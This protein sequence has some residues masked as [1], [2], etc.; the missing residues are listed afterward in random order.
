V[1]GLRIR[2]PQPA[3]VLALI[4][5]VVAMAGTAYAAVNLP[6]NSVGTKQLK[7]NSVTTAKIKK[8]AITGAKV[9]AHT[10][11][12]SDINLN[13]LGTV[14]SA[15]V[16]NS[17]AAPEG[18]HVV[19]APGEPGFEEGA[20]NF[21]TIPPGLNVGPVGFY[22]DHEG[23]VHLEGVAKVPGNFIF[24]LPPGYRPAAGITQ[25]FEAGVFIF[26]SSTSI[27]GVDVS[28]KVLSTEEN[29]ILNGITFRAGS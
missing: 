26:G 17:L 14:P 25:I 28:G 5:L 20:S 6:K 12:G 2:R 9:K 10:L 8:N 19:G 3:T 7:K 4:A 15:S 29:V 23:I 11:V 1:K 18:V 16:A 21:G 13:K 27:E 22:K 24:T